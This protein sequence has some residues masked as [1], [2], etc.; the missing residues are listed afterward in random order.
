MLLISFLTVGGAANS[1][2]PVQSPSP[3]PRDSNSQSP[4]VGT[5]A[6]TEAETPNSSA[7]VAFL[8]IRPDGTWNER[9]QI[10]ARGKL[11]A[12]MV[13][14]EG[15]CS[16]RSAES[17]V[18]ET[19]RSARTRDGSHWTPSAPQPPAL[20]ELKGKELYSGGWLFHRSQ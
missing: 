1:Q 12:T 16:Q 2:A 14:A 15:R 8:A 7:M 19:L 9:L 6:H 13:M 4:F 11:V 5:W 18:C 17:I 3:P 20:I 10:G